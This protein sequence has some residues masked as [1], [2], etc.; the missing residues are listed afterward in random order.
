MMLQAF[1][2]GQDNDGLLVCGTLEK[3]I[4]FDATLNDGNQRSVEFAV[5]V[6]E[7]FEPRR[8]IVCDGFKLSKIKRKLEFVHNIEGDEGVKLCC[9]V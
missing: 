2:G 5:S 4:L 8:I 6:E 7:C 3:S 9:A 1:V